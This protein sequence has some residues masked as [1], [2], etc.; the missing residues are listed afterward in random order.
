MPAEGN[1]RTSLREKL[2][3][4]SLLSKGCL[5]FWSNSDT[6][7]G[8]LPDLTLIWKGHYVAV[9]L[10]APDGHL[11]PLQKKCLSEVVTAGGTSCVVRKSERRGFYTCEIYPSEHSFEF[12]T[13]ESFLRE[14]D[15]RRS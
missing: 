11:R 6:F 9:E 4:F 12:S 14:L 5:K 13:V 2:K 7:V 10:K 1:L 15:A 8:G 3:Q